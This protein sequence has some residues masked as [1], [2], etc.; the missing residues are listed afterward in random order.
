LKGKKEKGKTTCS[1]LCL[2]SQKD[3]WQVFIEA[4]GIHNIG[5]VGS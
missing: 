2:S 1:M 3:V 5:R 4:C